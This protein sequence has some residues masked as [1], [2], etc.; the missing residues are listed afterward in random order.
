[1]T[2]FWAL[3][4]LI[5]A[6]ALALAAR[7]LWRRRGAARVS[8]QAMNAAVYREQ[9]RDLE[10]DLAAGVLSRADYDIA[11][12]ELERRV[13]D[14]VAPQ[15]ASAAPQRSWVAVAGIAAIPALALATYLAVGNPASIALD[16]ADGAIDNAR[17]VPAE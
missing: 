5:A 4:A 16:E 8:R 15:A 13:L 14:E 10:A 9:T 1:M 12:Q 2:L 11:R 6:V 17:I 7:P 3:G